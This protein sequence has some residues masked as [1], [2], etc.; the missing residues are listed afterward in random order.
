MNS[1]PQHPRI[2][3]WLGVLAF[4]AAQTLVAAGLVM[5][6]DPSLEPGLRA[7]T[8]AAV[9]GITLGAAVTAWILTQL[10]NR[11]AVTRPALAIAGGL[12]AS[13]MRLTIPLLAVAWLQLEEARNSLSLSQREFIAE[14]IVV[15]YL[16]LLFVDIL[17]N[18]LNGRPQ[19]DQQN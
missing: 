2:S 8:V 6:S 3:L 5:Q 4:L 9:S 12:A 15:S 13:L 14:T 7:K 10:A 17:L 19:F 11:E 16:A 1:A 18:T